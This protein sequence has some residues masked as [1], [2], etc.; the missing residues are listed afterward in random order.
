MENR[1]QKDFPID[2]DFVRLKSNIHDPV[3]DYKIF[4]K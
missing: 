3:F 1:T 2:V 4:V